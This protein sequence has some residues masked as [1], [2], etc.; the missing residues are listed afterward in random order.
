MRCP[1]CQFDHELQTTECLKCGIVFARYQAAL[2]AE[3]T[4][5]ADSAAPQS[6]GAEAAPAGPMGR[7]MPLSKSAAFPAQSD[8]AMLEAAARARAD[9]EAAM[10]KARSDA[11]REFKARAVALPAALIVARLLVGTGWRMAVRMLTMVLHESGHA[12]TSW[13]T[14]RWAI[15]ML[16]VTQMSENQSWLLILVLMGGLGYGGFLAWKAKRWGWLS[17]T[18]A[19]LLLQLVILS[20]PAFTQGALR[21][22]GGDGG[23][24]VLA[25]ILMAL[26]YAPR[27]SALYKSWGLRWGLLAYGALAF[28]DVYKI[29][30]GPWE[31]I[32]FGELEGVNLSDPS[33]LT[34][35]YGWSVPQLVDRYVHLATA[36]LVAL[37]ALYAWGLFSAYQEMRH[38]KPV[39]ME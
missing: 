10:A 14:G 19:V 35:F 3:R 29:W 38:P 31:D 20:R 15:P 30:S 24:L 36:C 32:P 28:M 37:A 16:W 12:I 7:T 5:A 39:E 9:T 25:A 22:F 26:F 4:A 2:E 13:L 17:A 21:T 8:Q 34:Q 23:A 18:G 33:L 11:A 1:K 6:I 27:T